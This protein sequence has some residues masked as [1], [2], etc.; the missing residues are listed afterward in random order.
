[1]NRLVWGVAVVL[2]AW[3]FSSAAWAQSMGRWNVPSTPAQFFGYGYGPGHQAPIVRAPG[4]QPL[5]VP[6]LA[7]VPAGCQPFCQVGWQDNDY[8]DLRCID[9]GCCHGP[10]EPDAFPAIQATP[11]TAQPPVSPLP[12]PPSGPSV[13]FVPTPPLPPVGNLSAPSVRPVR[14]SY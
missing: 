6:R 8:G 2:A 12:S 13:H 14:R 5:R 1:M 7:V 11:A 10:L 4:Y 9:A 3:T